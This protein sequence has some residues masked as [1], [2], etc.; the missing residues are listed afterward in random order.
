MASA[1]PRPSEMPSINAMGQW[2]APTDH[3]KK[4]IKRPRNASEP[5]IKVTTKGLLT[6]A[7]TEIRRS[8]HSRRLDGRQSLRENVEGERMLGSH[9]WPVTNN[10]GI[11]CLVIFSD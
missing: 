6:R 9:D 5:R 7:V 3:Q 8:Y 11:I 2:G 10:S 1:A 4:V